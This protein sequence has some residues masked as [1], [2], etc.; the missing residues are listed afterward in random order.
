MTGKVNTG[1]EKLDSVRILE[2]GFHPARLYA[3]V[4]LGKQYFSHYN[5]WTDKIEFVFEFPGLRQRFYADDTEER[6]TVTSISF[7]VSMG[8]KSNLRPFIES[9]IGKKMT[10]QEAEQFN[11]YSLADKYYLVQVNHSEPDKDGNVYADIVSATVLQQRMIDPA[12]DMT[13]YNPLH[14]YHIPTHGFEGPEFGN[15]PQ[16]KRER[17]MASEEG[18]EHKKAGRKFAEPDRTSSNGSTAQAPSAAAPP[19]APGPMASQKPR[20]QMLVS[21]YTYE[22]YKG[23]G[24]TDEM[25]VQHGKAKLVQPAAPAAPP[26]AAAPPPAPGQ[27]YNPVLHSI[28]GDHDDSDL[29]DLPM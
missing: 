29:D 7:T 1:P 9:M 26:A 19:A 28:A 2:P 12:I 23:S 14:L 11:I 18:I 17:I 24:W 22:Q 5:K 6:P 10:D 3:I 20:L 8:R 13:P 25:L 15:L 27:P 21:D 4:H 16:Y